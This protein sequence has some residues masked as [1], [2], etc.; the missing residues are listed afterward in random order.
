MG[1]RPL[2]RKA[3]HRA[4]MTPVNPL[5]TRLIHISLSDWTVIVRLKLFSN[6]ERPLEWNSNVLCKPITSKKHSI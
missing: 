5:R 2:L 1:T 4:M 6:G 3:R